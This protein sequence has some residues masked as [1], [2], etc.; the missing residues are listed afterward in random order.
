MQGDKDQA[1]FAKIIDLI[2]KSRKGK[3]LGVFAKDKMS[4]EFIDLWKAAL[5]SA[6]LEPTVDVSAA[7]A[8]IMSLKDD[9]EINLTKRASQ[10][11]V[12]VYSKYLRQQIME[13]IDSDKKIRHNKLSEMVEEAFQNKKYV[14]Q[15]TD[16]S[17]VESCYPT[18]IQSGGNYNLKFSVQSDKNTLD[19][20]TIVCMLGARY[21]SYCSNIVR[22][23][24]VNPSEEQKEIYSFLVNL[25][26]HIIE[27]L[28][29]GVK[30]SDVHN[31]GMN[32][33]TEHKRDLVK[34]L[35]K[36]FG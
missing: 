3:T 27:K 32:Y 24:M 11:S 36:S 30:L 18:I 19:F 5:T 33:A 35:T 17:Q 8:Y 26:E 10:M 29:D 31:E 25:Q 2:Q 13:V 23:L 1:N 4:S 7:F 22:T 12:D 9:H 21:K 16:T 34:N 20:G 15:N 28:R 6:K 14:G